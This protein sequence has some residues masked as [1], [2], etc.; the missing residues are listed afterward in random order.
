MHVSIRRLILWGCL[1]AAALQA[2]IR[3]ERDGGEAAA[4]QAHA[5]LDAHTWV[6]VVEVFPASERR[7]SRWMTVFE[8]SGRLWVYQPD[9]GTESLSVYAGRLAADKANLGAVLRHLDRGYGR[10][11]VRVADNTGA[12]VA[13]EARWPV[14]RL[15]EGCFVES[16]GRYHALRAQGAA[17]SG[18]HLLLYY[19]GEGARRRGHTVLCYDTPA[20]WRVWDESNPGKA[21]TWGETIP[22]DALT[23]AKLLVPIDVATQLVAAKRLPMIDPRGAQLARQSNDEKTR[24]PAIKG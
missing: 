11:R 9:R 22:A 12:L 17:V 6:Q 23:Q 20:G 15:P 18:A 3:S 2:G 7:G 4:R 14:G 16:L 1:T 21:P 24:P 8:L 10:H 13:G 5:R 19:V